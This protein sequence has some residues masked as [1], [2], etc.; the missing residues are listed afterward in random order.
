M[1]EVSVIIPTYNRLESVIRAIDSV[2][3]QKN[4]SVECI[5]IDDCSTDGTVRYIQDNYSTHNITIIKN[6]CRSGAQFSR[7][8]GLIAAQGVFIAFLDS[9]DVFEMNTLSERVQ[10][11]NEF[12]LD[13]LFS[14]YRVKL[15]GKNW[16]LTKNVT[17]SVRPTPS[18]YSEALKNFKIAPLITIMF[19]RSAF[20]DLQ[21]DESLRS[22]HD[23]DL[24][25]TLIFQGRY[26][27]DNIFAATIFQHSGERV[28]SQRNL[29][30]GDA[31][32]LKKYSEDLY[33]YHGAN[34]FIKKQSKV[35]SGLLVN[36]QFMIA[37]RSLLEHKSIAPLPRVLVLTLC[38]LPYQFY[39]TVRI[40]MLNFFA[41][42]VL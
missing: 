20:P 38:I 34:F 23:D 22:G 26:E 42:K 33:Y 39:Q 24:S 36:L 17:Q 16:E 7:N 9:D 2:F 12:K 14:A 30:I 4:V 6:S 37:K 32:L 11:C 1:I 19:R 8:Q 25:L 31:Q 27:F 29:A 18:N 40:K 41:R 13:S 15:M 5:L 3:S 21:L 35:I 10:R 28:A